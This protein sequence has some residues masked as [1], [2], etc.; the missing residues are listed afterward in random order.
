[1]TLRLTPDTLFLKV[2]LYLSISF[3]TE[4]QLAEFRIDHV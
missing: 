2:L 1:M 4:Q 3:D